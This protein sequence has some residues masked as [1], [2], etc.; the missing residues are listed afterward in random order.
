MTILSCKTIFG[1]TFSAISENLL[2]P[3]FHKVP[4]LIKFG[5]NED[6]FQKSGRAIFLPLLSPN[7]MSSFGKIVGEVLQT[8]EKSENI[9]KRKTV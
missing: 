8:N 5:Q 3:F 4:N 9:K 1:L 2:E 6:F 7:F